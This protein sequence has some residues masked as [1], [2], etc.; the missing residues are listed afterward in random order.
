MWQRMEEAGCVFLPAAGGRYGTEVYEVGTDG[1]YWSSTYYYD[2]GAYGVGFYDY[3]LYV[4][5][6]GRVLGLSVRL[7]RDSD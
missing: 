2:L 1:N 3:D 7:V 4:D 6:Y 5:Y